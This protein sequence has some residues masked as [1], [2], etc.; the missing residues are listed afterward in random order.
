MHFFVFFI[1][2][3]PHMVYFLSDFTTKRNKIQ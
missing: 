1:E 2:N 3:P